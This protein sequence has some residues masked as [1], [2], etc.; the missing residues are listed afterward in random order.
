[1]NTHS[2]FPKGAEGWL[3]ALL[4]AG[5]LVFVTAFWTVVGLVL[6]VFPALYFR[7]AVIVAQGAGI[8]ALFGLIYGIGH[9]LKGFIQG[10]IAR[11][12]LK[13]G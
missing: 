8:G 2:Y 13:K 10:R 11:A 12:K 7:D 9:G 5:A 3:V 6:A 4:I 1:M